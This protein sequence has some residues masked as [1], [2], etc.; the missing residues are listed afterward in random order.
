MWSE[1][2]DREMTNIFATQD[3]IAR[4]VTTALKV[5]LM[6]AGAQGHPASSRGTSPEA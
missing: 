1:S 5:K 2:Y 4:S 6:T 3:D